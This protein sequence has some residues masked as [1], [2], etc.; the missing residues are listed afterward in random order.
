MEYWQQI[1]VE[2]EGEVKINDPKVGS[3]FYKAEPIKTTKEV[4]GV[5]V[6]AHVTAGERQ[7]VLS[8]FNTVV[9]VLLLAILL[10][11]VVAWLAA[12][13][14]LSPLRNFSNKYL[15]KISLKILSNKMAGKVK[16][17]WDKNKC[18]RLYPYRTCISPNMAAFIE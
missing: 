9:R 4:I 15:G 14:I 8:S 13:R 5:F 11:S 7:E 18:D 10:A 6:V 12:G 1:T 16:N 3:V 2:K 17:L